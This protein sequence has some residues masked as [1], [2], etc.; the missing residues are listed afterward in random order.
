MTVFDFAPLFARDLP[1]AAK[2]SG[3][4]PEF[5][6]TGGHNDPE[7]IP[8]EALIEAAV[9][10]LRARGPHMAMYSMQGGPQ[11]LRDL[12]QVVADKLTRDRGAPTDPDDV[13]ITSGSL[14]GMDLVNQ[15]LV[16][17]GDT[18]IVEEDTYGG[19]LNRLRRRGAKIVGAPLDEQGLRID[20]LEAQLDEL[21]A[22]GIKP[23][24]IYTIPTIQN[25]TGS[26]LPVERRRAL[27]ALA[28]ARGIAVF[29]DE[30]YADL[31]F[32]ED[33]PPALRGMDPEAVIHIGSFSKTLA[34]ALRLGYLVADWAVL[35][36]IMPL[37][38]DAGTG[39]IEQMVVADYFG[40]HFHGHVAALK[41]RLAAKLD[42]MVEAV[43][44]EFGTAAEFVRPK[45][46]IF[47]WMRIPGVDTSALCPVALA[48]GVE[49]NP[50]AEWSTRADARDCLRLCFALPT[51]EK[52]REGVAKLAE[53]C[54]RETGIPAVS[55]NIR[56]A[57]TMSGDPSHMCEGSQASEN[58]REYNP[59]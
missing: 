27:L 13:L 50:G 7:G 46:G 47:F 10:Q 43:E 14:Q 37:K 40:S 25:P 39:A 15:L 55:A 34:P 36:R 49:F 38:T 44:R 12:R 11:G 4:P 17:P 16:D 33:A 19:T 22:K 18:V 51:E 24:Y 53:I 21:A 1:P 23:K 42:A 31:V 58:K 26:V 29:E 3:T 32:G 8:V 56:H 57:A 5:N 28:R 59:G 20:A 35:S 41:P 54:R 52:I 2:R 48:E 45:G 30:C 6:F 9:R